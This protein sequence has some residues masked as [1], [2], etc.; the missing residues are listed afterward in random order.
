M[1][2]DIL[3]FVLSELEKRRNTWPVVA[4]ESGVPYSTIAKIAQ[5]QIKDPKVGKVQRLANY[6]RS[7]A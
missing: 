1:K 6:F 5:G 2:D 7:A 4:R 3:P